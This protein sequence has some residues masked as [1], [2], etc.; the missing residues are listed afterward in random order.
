MNVAGLD[1]EEFSAISK[2]VS[3]HRQL[4]DVL[5][6]DEIDKARR[7]SPEIIT[8]DEYTHDIVFAWSESIYLVYDTN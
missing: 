1:F 2:V 8:Q 6:C 7:L 5:N 3:G 4:L